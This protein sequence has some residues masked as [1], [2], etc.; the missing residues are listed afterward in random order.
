[1]ALA[2]AV[3]GAIECPLRCTYFKQGV[4]SC[5]NLFFLK[6]NNVKFA[7]SF[8]EKWNVCR[9]RS[10]LSNLEVVYWRFPSVTIPFLVQC[11]SLSSSPHLIPSDYP[12]PSAPPPPSPSVSSPSPSSVSLQFNYFLESLQWISNESP[13]NRTD[14]YALHLSYPKVV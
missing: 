7:P 10:C 14:S 2:L 12:P 1:M 5:L 6:M 9:M 13:G 8:T 4:T 3:F 11:L